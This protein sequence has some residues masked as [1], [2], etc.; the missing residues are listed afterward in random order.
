MRSHGLA[1]AITCNEPCR[2]TAELRASA[3]TARALRRRGLRA[4]GVLA[5]GATTGL[6]TGTRTVRAFPNAAGRRALK[7]L[8]SATYVLTIA[9][10][11]RAGNIRHLTRT[12]RA[13]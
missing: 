11:D 5:R 10:M 7:R 12:L 6:A 3:A 13:R 1:V 4:D 9:V 8:P 2:G